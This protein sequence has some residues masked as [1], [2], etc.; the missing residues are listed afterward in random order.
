MEINV[1][2]PGMLTT[3]QD[4]GRVGFRHTGLATG[5]AMDVFALR[6]ANM[7]I[8]NEEKAVGLEMTMTGA[9]MEFSSDALVAVTGAKMSGLET[10]RPHFVRAGERLKFGP[11]KAGCR[12]YVAI[13][14]GFNAPSVLGGKG[15]DLRTGLGGH[16]GRALRAGD[17]LTVNDVKREIVGLWSVDPRILPA[18]YAGASVRVIIGPE[19]TDFTQ[20]INQCNFVVSKDS[21]RMG[22]RLSGDKLARKSSKEMISTAVGTGTVQVP[23]DGSPII[24][25]ADAQTIGGYPRI[26]QV[27]QVDLPLIAQLRPGDMVRFDIVTLAEAH[28]LSR[29]RQKDIGF[30]REGL[31]GKFR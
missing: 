14:G 12:T 21:D 10:G 22:L 1:L 18:Y 4:L 28:R 17:V 7:L 15:T 25:M 19:A 13:S 8:G 27:I 2:S 29:D 11:T 5:G 23:P 24:L 6:L 26:A 3:L 9:E 31:R 16:E 30:L 20:D